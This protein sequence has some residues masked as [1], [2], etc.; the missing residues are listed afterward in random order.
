MEATDS[1][2]RMYEDDRTTGRLH[3]IEG[4]IR[5]DGPSQKIT[6]KMMLKLLDSQDSANNCV[7]TDPCAYFMSY[8][9]SC[10]DLLTL[11][12]LPA[13]YASL[14]RDLEI[15]HIWI[16]TPDAGLR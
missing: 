16:I 12:R 2:I 3:L 11:R 8:I 10:T 9:A 1:V 6:K 5:D 13:G 14:V 15:N 4:N 7:S